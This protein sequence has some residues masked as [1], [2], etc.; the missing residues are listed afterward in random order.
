[1]MDI[2]MMEKSTKFP[3]LFFQFTV[4]KDLR[5]QATIIS[6]DIDIDKKIFEVYF[7]E[8]DESCLHNNNGRSR[9]T[10]RREY[11]LIVKNVVKVIRYPQ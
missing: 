8:E 1:M 9:T 6:T 5:I 4:P 2:K 11:I 3:V 7:A 10:L